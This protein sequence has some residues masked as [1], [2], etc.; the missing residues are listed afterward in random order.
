MILLMISI[1]FFIPLSLAQ[2]VEQKACCEKTKS[3]ETCLYTEQSDCDLNYPA[4]SSECSQTSYCKI[5]CCHDSE[6]GSCYKSTPK[7]KCESFNG[8]FSNDEFC[9][10]QECQKGCCVLGSQ[11]SLNTQSKCLNTFTT[12]TDLDMDWRLGFSEDEC[13]NLCREEDKG[14]CVTQ[15]NRYI[16]TSRSTCPTSTVQLEIDSDIGFYKDTLCSSLTDECEP[17]DHKAC[18]EDDVY[19]FDSCDNQED[20]AEDCDYEQGTLCMLRDE[21]YTCASVDCDSTYDNILVDTDGGSRKLGESW[22]EYDGQVGFGSDLVG[23]RHYRHMCI[24]GEEITEP[25]K[26]FREEYCGQAKVTNTPRGSYYESACKSNR[27]QTCASCNTAVPGAPDYA[28]LVKR[29]RE[30]CQNNAV[31]DCAWLGSGEEDDIFSEEQVIDAQSSDFGDAQCKNIRTEVINCPSDPNNPDQDRDA[32]ID[33]SYIESHQ[34]SF[35]AGTPCDS[36]VKCETLKEVTE[37]CA[38]VAKSKEA[39]EKGAGKGGKC[40]PLVPPGFA[41]WE[42]SSQASEE[43]STPN[44]G[45][46]DSFC[47]AGSSTCTVVYQKVKKGQFGSCVRDECI[48]NCVCLE[49][50]WVQSTNALC[51]TQGDCG[52]YYNIAGDFTDGGYYENS[53]GGP[54]SQAL[55]GTFREWVDAGKG[56]YFGEIDF[57]EESEGGLLGG[58]FGSFLSI[59][60]ILTPIVMIGLKLMGA[61]FTLGVYQLSHGFIKVGGAGTAL[62]AGVLPKDSIITAGGFTINPNSAGSVDVIKGNEVIKNIKQGSYDLSSGETAVIKNADGVSANAGSTAKLPDA[63]GE[64][65]VASAT[66]QFLSKVLVIITVITSILTLYNFFFGEQEC[67]TENQVF[68]AR[69]LPWEQ[70][71]TNKCNLCNQEHKTCTEYRCKSLGKFC[72]VVNSEDPVNTKCVETHPNDVTSPVITP[73]HEIAQQNNYQITEASNGFTITPNFS[74]YQKIKFGIKTNELAKCK[75]HNNRTNSYDEMPSTF[76]GLPIYKTQHNITLQLKDGEQYTYFVRCTDFLKN[77]NIPEYM[78][79]FNTERGPDLTPPVIDLI[80][81]ATGSYVKSDLTETPISIFVDDFNEVKCKWDFSE[82]SYED[83]KNDFTCNTNRDALYNL[84]E[85]QTQLTGISET[86]SI[87]YF[88]CQD[89]EGNTNQPY[90]FT[91]TGTNP[92]NISSVIPEGDVFDKELTLE[93]T[94]ISGAESGVSNCRFSTNRDIYENM[95][96]FFNTNSLQHTQKL[97]LQP[98]THNYF[99][100]CRD[101]ADNEASSSTTFRLK[102]DRS[103][104]QLVNV[105]K[106]S[107]NLKITLDEIATCQY[108]NS[109]FRYGQGIQLGTLSK[110][111][112]TPIIS[113]VYLICQDRFNNTMREIVIYPLEE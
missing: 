30:C 51:R 40:V 78:I 111:H 76:F 74:P 28:G 54:I 81:K 86:S 66:K 97:N 49:D 67:G 42:G 11:C 35:P 98:G 92:L 90:Q 39:K 106:E 88:M 21:E 93:A 56:L 22:C 31:R 110:E 45:A 44:A 89:T 3:G 52:A 25:C 5:G 99:V 6:E 58:I 80:S 82:L 112:S 61:S 107:G 101:S 113:E 70:P 47:N 104:S 77:Q 85:C 63:G 41:F 32:V 105:Y 102:I 1:I 69:C 55:V 62:Q 53:P 4:E 84:F 96:D 100:K 15:D 26:D 38:N 91:L 9:N 24:N 14:C 83:M 65:Q 12:Y 36:E 23:S 103:P 27:Y 7:A 34:E 109:T 13:I 20:L 46:G 72:N 17:Q 43:G 50:S 94:T 29:D 60:G 95:I 79:N 18:V 64:V 37:A 87:Y 19:Y 33:C 59:Q 71:D 16:Y 68:I 2:P 73:D 10:V 48:Q 8:T 57:E 108:S 75:L